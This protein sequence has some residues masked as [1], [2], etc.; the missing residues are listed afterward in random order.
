MKIG[1]LLSSIG[2]TLLMSSCSTT[3]FYQVYNVKPIGEAVTISD[4]LYF[5]D[6]NCK[7]TYNLW[8]NGG[9]MGFVFYNKTDKSIFLNLNESFFIFNGI[10]ND[11]FQDRVFTNSK[12]SS[13][14][15]ISSATA[16]KS[17]SGNNYWNLFQT[18]RVQS[19]KSVGVVAS[20]GY[21][22]SYNEAKVIS[23][24]SKTSKFIAEY[25]ISQSLYRDCD[26][27]KY[28]TAK[29]VKSKFF[30]K[31]ESPIVFSNRISYTIDQSENAIKLENEF[32]VAEISNYP[33]N[34]MLESKYEEYCGQ[35]RM[36]TITIFKATSPNRFYIKYSKGMDTWKY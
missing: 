25:N 6:E 32:Y 17:V 28:P 20:N 21:S 1:K 22:V 29:Q 24:P 23:I 30:D 3:S 7:I 26:L 12:N 18:N 8:S 35:K 34:K 16:S 27:L 2:L 11:Y 9:N 5:E 33:E 19:S 14:T 4:E 15:A 31:S 36:K 10:A 13:A